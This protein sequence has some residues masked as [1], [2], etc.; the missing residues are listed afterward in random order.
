MNSDSGY[1]NRIYWSSDNFATR[2]YL[3]IDN[4]TGTFSVGSFA[5]GTR[6]D[7]GIDNGVGGFFR[8]GT[9]SQNG[10][11]FQHTRLSQTSSR[12]QVGFEDLWGGCDQD[13]ND[14]IVN[15]TGIHSG[16]TAGDTPTP[17]PTD[18]SGGNRSGLGN[19]ANPGQG[20]GSANSP[21]QGT[22]NPSQSASGGMSPP[23]ST[24]TGAANG[25]DN[26]GNRSGLGDGTNP[27]QGA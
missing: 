2:H 26:N 13:F 10:D 25:N 6:I 8:T 16:S 14:A 1:D 3:G 9:A 17:P 4:Q 18:S 27:G 20:A 7:I 19:G 11:N 12:M 24:S 21:N 22:N 5:A 23:A 15:V